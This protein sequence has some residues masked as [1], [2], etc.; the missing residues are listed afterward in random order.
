[1]VFFEFMGSFC[2]GWCFR[3]IIGG[4]W[5]VYFYFFIVVSCNWFLFLGDVNVG[6]VVVIKL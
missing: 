5:E 6:R 3:G 2:F 4:G 1:M